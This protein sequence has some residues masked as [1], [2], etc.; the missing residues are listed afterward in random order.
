MSGLI[1]STRLWSGT[2]NMGVAM[3]GMGAILPG[4]GVAV[5]NE[6]FRQ[7]ESFWDCCPASLSSLL[8]WPADNRRPV[9]M[10]VAVVEQLRG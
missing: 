4:R 6:T 2:Q 1:K 10:A 7:A 8:Q 3:D 9:V 5:N